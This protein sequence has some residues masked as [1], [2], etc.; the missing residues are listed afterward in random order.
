[1]EQPP[2]DRF[3]AIIVGC[4]VTGLTLANALSCRQIDY[5]VLEA[6]GALSLSESGA[7]LVLL[8]NGAR[9]FGQLGVMPEIKRASAPIHRHS[10]WLE[11]GRLLKI[12]ATRM[13]PSTR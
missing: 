3:K 8:P 12:L 6:R 7:G 10:T 2:G 4:S 5:I 11:D 1:M 9:I 13:L